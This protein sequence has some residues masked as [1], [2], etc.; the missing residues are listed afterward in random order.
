LAEDDSGIAAELKQDAELYREPSL[1]APSAGKL[2]KGTILTLAG[3]RKGDFVSVQ[4]ELV[5]GEA[6]GWVKASALADSTADSDE[7]T[8][9]RDALAPK[10][11]TKTK[12]KLEPPKKKPFLPKDESLLLRRDPSFL[13]GIFGGPSFHIVDSQFTNL[14]Y[15]GVGFHAGGYAGIF[16]DRSATL[17]FQVHYTAPGGTAEDGS[18]VS[19]RLL[20]IALLGEIFWKQ[21]RLF[22][23]FSYALGLG[24]G[25]L[26]LAWALNSSKDLSS[27][28][29]VL[30]L[31]YA[32]PVSDILNLIPRFY[33]SFSFVRSP[34]GFQHMGLSLALEFQG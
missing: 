33:Y 14:V 16:L 32:L 25:E 29:L 18:T 19:M 20:D 5:D 27:P 23:G 2:P 17:K 6:S 21:V 9:D 1:T 4:V 13:Y 24:F 12:T 15:M 26:P 3:E 11:G 30:G 10:A 22:G 31:G 8:P 7:E 28:G 34:V